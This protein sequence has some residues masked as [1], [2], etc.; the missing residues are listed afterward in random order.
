MP[1]RP[2][3]HAA[4]RSG[5]ARARGGRWRPF[6]ALLLAALA[7]G[8]I[9]ALLPA[10]AQAAPPTVRSVEAAPARIA[11]DG[12]RSTITVTVSPGTGTEAVT[13][14]TLTTTLGAFGSAAGPSRV[15]VALSGRADGTAVAEATLVGD[16]RLGSAAVTASA[17]A[18]A[19]ATTVTFFGAPAAITFETPSAGA[20]RSAAS[21]P[22]LIVQVHDSEGVAVPGASVTFTADRGR[23]LAG[24]T[25]PADD[26]A[27]GSS[28]TI[29]TGATGRASAYLHADPGAVRV[30]A[31]AGG[32]TASLSLTLHGPPTRL[33]LTALARRVHLGDTP[34][35]APPGTLVASLFDE[36]GRPVPG[37]SVRFGADTEGATVLHSGEG[38][39]GV[40][41]A[42]GRAAA[43]V[44]AADAAETGTVTIT[45]QAGELSATAAVQIVGPA[46]RLQLVLTAQ[47]EAGAYDVAALVTDSGGQAVPSGYQ[48]RFSAVGATPSAAAQFDPVTAET[49]D[50]L[51]RTVFTLDGATEGVRV[52]A[53]VA[54]IEIDV[55]ASGPLPAAGQAAVISLAEGSNLITWPG[56][57]VG[58]LGRGGRD[59]GSGHGDLALRRVAGLAELRAGRRARRRF[60]HRPRRPAGRHDQRSRRL[61]GPRGGGGGGDGNGRGG[62][63]IGRGRG[64]GTG[65]AFRCLQWRHAPA[66]FIDTPPARPG[67]CRSEPVGVVNP[68]SVGSGL[69]TRRARLATILSK[70]PRGD[71]LVSRR[72][73][74]GARIAAVVVLSSIRS[75]RSGASTHRRAGRATRPPAIAAPAETEEDG[76]DGGAG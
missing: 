41:G 34:F 65:G 18:S 51:A 57:G 29:A 17:G 75:R 39:S 27:A 74:G 15:S 43:H 37:V 21:P 6:L 32:A 62:R 76:S 36:G 56:P 59:R 3:M 63:R 58:G 28:Y 19:R 9:L 11:A 69:S 46:A 26:A 22:R 4:A 53:Y 33:E 5:P 16:G 35:A 64:L 42:S 31:A 61:D 48:V 38:E 8:L 12:G 71:A 44:S 50:G 24:S 10:F 1:M 73:G 20:V 47:E 23:L 72:R 40:T 66:S 60:R 25:P 54:E 55:R 70:S 45:A 49:V 68:A 14:V 30:R 7:A 67:D 13:Q 52:R 2:S